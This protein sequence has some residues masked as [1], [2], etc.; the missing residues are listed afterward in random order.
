M[1]QRV[2]QLLHGDCMQRL[3]DLEEASL[4]A[5]VFDPPYDLTSTAGRGFMGKRWDATGVAFKE[6]FW[7]LVYS[8]LKPGGLVKALG[9]TR[10]F[11][12]M[13]KAI[14]T[15]GFVDVRLEAWAYGCLDASS[16]ILTKEGWKRGV[17]VTVGEEVMCW[18][19][20]G[21]TFML[22]PVEAR[23]A[24]PYDGPMVRLAGAAVDQW[25][26]LDHRVY[27]KHPVR[28]EVH[29]VPVVRM[30]DWESIE[31]EELRSWRTRIRLP[32]AGVHEGR[33]LD[34][35]LNYARLL[36][37]VW[38]AGRYEG[39]GRAGL[40]LSN[41]SPQR[42]VFVDHVGGLLGTLMREN[43]VRV[44]DE[45]S[46]V[47]RIEGDLAQR[48]QKDLPNRHPTYDLLWRMTADEKA[49]FLLEALMSDE[50]DQT[51]EFYH[52][53]TFDRL[54]FQTLAHVS[55]WRV[56]GTGE[57]D[58]VQVVQSSY[59]ELLR[60][61][62]SLQ[63]YAGHIWCVKVP[64]GAFLAKR[65]RHLFV[66]GNSGFPKSL[67]VS[68]ALDRQAKAER[69]VIGYKR[70]VGGEDLNDVVHG[71]PV[72]GNAGKGSGGVG[73]YGT[74]AKQV[75]IDVPVTAPAT[76][77]AKLWDGYGT[78]L[79]PAWEAIVVARRPES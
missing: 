37:W 67:N 78:G 48:V 39:P 27:V 50:G 33:G 69:R 11:H 3:L 15:V 34:D 58:F 65:G 21:G 2:F 17:D 10:T 63:D 14:E 8:R 76:E 52:D 59:V 53:N 31:A 19:P 24:T 49:A 66:T 62:A 42:D 54:W 28:G 29:G 60:V 74:G 5:F 7:R 51:G 35:R 25:L 55:G 79:K 45:R 6:D 36:A 13:K 12:K 61:E 64:T 73:A 1:T 20:E 44:S 40:V 47:F 77:L 22:L 71:K 75:A 68:K 72:R 23:I 32:V 56:Q 46:I 18:D 4:D 70:G 43:P 57:S 9:G 30:S 26:T 16:E 38:V 41:A